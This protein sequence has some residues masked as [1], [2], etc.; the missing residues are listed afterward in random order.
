MDLTP[1][2]RIPAPRARP[3]A[4]PDF[5]DLVI[6]EAG[7][8]PRPAVTS[9]A[10]DM[11]DLA[12]SLIRVL[13]PDGRAV[14]PWAEE[15]PI[16][17][18][19][20]GLRSMMLTRAF[21][22]RMFRAQRQGKTCFYATCTGEE[23]V[24]CA[25]ALALRPTDM[26]FASYRQQGLLVARGYPLVNMANQVFSNAADPIKAR[27][28]PVLYSARDYG[29]FSVS[30]NVATQIC[31]AVGW[32]MALAYKGEDAIAASW[33]GEGGTAEGDFHHAMTFA[34]VY[35]APV[36]LNVVNN[37]WAIS[38]FQ[39]IAGGQETT[40][41]SKAIAYGLP[42]LRVDGN[43]FIAVYAATRWAAERARS[44]LGATL[45][46]LVTY[47]AG[48]H[49]TS[50]DPSRYRPMHEE[51][52][53]PRGDPIAR[54]KDHLIV[55]GQWSEAQHKQLTEDVEQSVETAVKQAEAIGTLGQS[56]PP[57]DEMF[58]QV[59][60][61]PDWRLMRQRQQAGG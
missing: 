25:Q 18:L 16:E 60:K 30:A 52:L 36:I 46:E 2:L 8:A 14:G 11:R 40:F 32:A 6:A 41:A 7:V 26:C 19:K 59:F 21:D 4:R 47:R 9:R 12:F 35:R 39:G 15:P 53:W 49:S 45:I 5:G 42:A 29:F 10:S 38:T 37:Q 27:Q 43:D 51:R 61:V 50:D 17:T 58:N 23:A 22:A 34:A 20:H 33:L 3:G 31:Q 56:K 57:I 48:P 55:C 24:A 54:L 44:N 28:L 13:S 1:K